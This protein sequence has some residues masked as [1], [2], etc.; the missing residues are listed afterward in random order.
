[1]LVQQEIL[2]KFEERLLNGVDGRCANKVNP[3]LLISGFA[4]LVENQS[5]SLDVIKSTYQNKHGIFGY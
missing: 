2:T 4:L 1:M 3:R 5:L